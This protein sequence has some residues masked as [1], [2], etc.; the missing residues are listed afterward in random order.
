MDEQIK[1]LLARTQQKTDTSANWELVNDFIPLK[2]EIIIYSDLNRIKLG[3]GETKVN[4]LEFSG[5]SLTVSDDENGTVFL[6]CVSAT[7][8]EGT[9]TIF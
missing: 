6:S 3:D 1:K 2:G 9:L 8:S 4:D 5:S 7:E